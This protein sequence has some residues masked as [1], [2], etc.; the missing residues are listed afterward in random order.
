MHDRGLGTKVV[1][2]QGRLTLSDNTLQAFLA[3]M[4]VHERTRACI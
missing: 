1:I 2:A 3:Q 4:T